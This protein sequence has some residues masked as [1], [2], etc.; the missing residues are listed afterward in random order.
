MGDLPN[1]EQNFTWGYI[2]GY[3]SLQPC[4]DKDSSTSIPALIPIVSMRDFDMDSMTGIDMV[5]VNPEVM[6]ILFHSH[7]GTL[8]F[9]KDTTPL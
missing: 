9:V 6:N 2:A 1:H 3:C 8:T 7:I 5:I 4:P